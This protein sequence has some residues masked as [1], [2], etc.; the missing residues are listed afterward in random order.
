[1][2]RSTIE[3]YLYRHFDGLQVV[4]IEWA[5]YHL[6]ASRDDEKILKQELREQLHEPRCPAFIDKRFAVKF[7]VQHL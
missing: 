5:F 6:Q 7:I 3:Q 4:P 2:R 1:M